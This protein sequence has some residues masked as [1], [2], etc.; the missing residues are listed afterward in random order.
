MLDANTLIELKQIEQLK[1]RYLRALDTQDWDLLESCLS[2]DVTTWFNNGAHSET[3]RETVMELYRT[4]LVPEFVSSHVA[5]HPEI[6]LRNDDEA[7]G[8]WRLEETVYYLDD[9]EGLGQ[10]KGDRVS[11]AAHYYD[12]YR[13]EDGSWKI[14]DTGYVSIYKE[15]VSKSGSVHRSFEPA[16]GRLRS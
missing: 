8:V 7:S 12:T 10:R 3:G 5:S 11:A 16:R 13:K 1:Y 14:S 2:E 9:H 15:T 6:T 4:I